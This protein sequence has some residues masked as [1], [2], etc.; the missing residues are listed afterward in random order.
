MK[1]LFEYLYV[2]AA[3]AISCFLFFAVLI[4]LGVTVPGQTSSLLDQCFLYCGLLYPVVLI[5]SYLIVTVRYI[6]KQK[7]G[8]IPVLPIIYFFIYF[9][10]II[11]SAV[12]Y[13]T[14]I[15]L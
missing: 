7:I 11:L 9:F 6:K 10:T 3:F 2:V 12:I 13:S 8:I 14:L 5:V 15:Y 4:V 1:K